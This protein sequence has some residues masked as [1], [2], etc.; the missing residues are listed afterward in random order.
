MAEGKIIPIIEPMGRFLSTSDTPWSLV[1]A[2]DCKRIIIAHQE[3]LPEIIEQMTV[4]NAGSPLPSRSPECTQLSL[5]VNSKCNFHCSYC[6]AAGSRTDEE[7]SAQ[8]LIPLIDGWFAGFKTDVI[9]EISFSGG[10]E[11]LLSMG[12]VEE[13]VA[14]AEQQAAKHGR[15]VNFSMATNGSLLNSSVLDFLERHRFKLF[16]SFEIIEDL[17]KS[18]R[19]VWEP[20]RSNL[21]EVL[22]R[23]IPCVIKCV[24]TCKSMARQ[25][26][27]AKSAIEGL[28]G[29]RC[30]TFNQSE[31]I[32]LSC[33]AE[34]Y[35]EYLDEV[36]PGFFEARRFAAS[37]GVTISSYDFQTLSRH[38]SRCCPVELMVTPHGGITFCTV[39]SSPGEALYQLVNTGEISPDGQIRYDETKLESLRAYSANTDPHCRYCAAREFCGGGCPVVR[40]SYPPEKLRIYCSGRRK[41]LAYMAMERIESIVHARGIPSLFEWL[42]GGPA[43]TERE[44]CI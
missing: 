21:I 8:R 30:I 24:I 16:F 32:A 19:G 7:L 11:P 12:K 40:A 13:I 5:L 17:Q 27:M 33:T 1:L 18:Q 9:P 3:E 39:A 36:I 22:R 20:V 23:G 43:L 10:G 28:P 37:H 26:E 29:V 38:S 31:L 15:K 34:K 35:R 4:R 14:V 42:A 44:F 6:Y 2:P 41:M 25:L